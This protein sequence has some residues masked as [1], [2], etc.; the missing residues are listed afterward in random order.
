MEKKIYDLIIIGAGPAGLTAAVY[1][2]RYKLD[3]LVLG[4]VAGGLILEAHKVCNF[5]TYEEIK[6]Y[7]LGQ[8]MASQVKAMRVPIN[9][10]EVI[11][12][13]KNNES[14]E[15]KTKK[16]IYFSKKIILAIGTKRR[17]LDVKGEKDFFGRGVSYCATCDGAFYKD[18]NVAIVGGGNSA[19]TAALLLSEYAKEVYIIYRKSEFTKAEPAWV[20]Q[21]LKNKKIKPIFN[22]N[23][24]EIKGSKN[25]EGVK[26]D[27]GDDINVDGVFIE[28]GSIP[29]NTL[30][31]QLG[32][33]LENGY[34]K[35][36]KNQETNVKGVYAAGDLTNNPLK[37]VVTACA[38]GAIAAKSAYEEVRRER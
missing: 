20:E 29:D 7:E 35:V 16:E 22:A 15:I 33:E 12:I 17:M 25:V 9:N 14:F 2:A 37:Q 21:V 31:N 10:E 26:L 3:V 36:N 34:I 24:M 38:E 32:L 6:G 30:S 27:K 13:K 18:K 19:L 8:K 28:I 4:R 5:P 11:E 1:A 23:I